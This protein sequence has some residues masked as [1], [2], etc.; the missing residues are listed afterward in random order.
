MAARYWVGGHVTNNNWNQTGSG[1][2]N[3]STTSGGAS[4]A[5]VPGASDDVIFDANGD[6]NSTIS[7]TITILSLTITSGLTS[8]IAHNAVLTVAGDVTLGANYTIT[9]SSAMTISATSTI[10]SNG[11][12]WPNSMTF[13]GLSTTKTI[14]GDLTIS[15]QLN[16]AFN[17]ANT[18]NKTTSEKIY[19]NGISVPSG[20]T[21][22]GTIE[23]VLTGGNWTGVSLGASVNVDLT[24]QGNITFVTAIAFGGVNKTLKYVSGTITQNSIPLNVANASTVSM[25]TSGI[26]W[27]NINMAATTCTLLSTLNATTIT[28]VGNTSFAG[29]FGFVVNTFIWTYTSSATVTLSPSVTYTINTLLDDSKATV[30]DHLFT[31][32]HASTK[33]IILMPNNGANLCNVNGGFTRIDASGGRSITTFG[34]TITDCTNVVQYYDYPTVAA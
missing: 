27:Y 23:I 5:S 33:A 18:I 28:E 21:P 17:Q 1:D 14:V 12:T 24:L 25:D 26:T 6:S 2:T 8:S 29:S 34:G 20:S 11:K 9:G 13:S 16:C 31:S 3:W 30:N 19:A 7:A 32:S 10:T 4:G 22:S 15:G